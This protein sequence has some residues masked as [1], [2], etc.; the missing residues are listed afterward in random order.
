LYGK[1]AYRDSVATELLPQELDF[2]ASCGVQQFANFKEV[3]V[4]VYKDY[5]V[6]AMKTE[7][8]SCYSVPGSVWDLVCL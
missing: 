2:Q 8:I 5:I 1:C 3:R 6:L 4:I 7:E